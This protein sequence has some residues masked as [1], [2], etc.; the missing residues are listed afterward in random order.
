MLC[1]AEGRVEW[2]NYVESSRAATVCHQFLWQ[3]VIGQVYRHRPFYLMARRNE[4]VRGILPLFLVKSRL[5]GKSLTSMPFLDY[6]GICADDEMIAQNLLQCALAMMQE[7]GAEYVELRQCEAPA[8]SERARLDKVTM[9]LDLSAGVEGVWH[10]LPAK[11]R[12]QVRKAEKSGLHAC[13]GGPELLED[14]YL[15]FS[16]NMRDLGSPVHHRDFFAHLFAQCGI[17][18]RLILVREGQRAVG[19]LV[20]LFFRDTVIV[21]WASSLRQYL[22]KCPN[23]LLYWTAIQ[24]ACARGCR[25]FDFGRSSIG[26][27]TYNFKLQWGAEA[28]QIYWRVLGS[29]GRR[30]M[31]PS[32]SESK[33]HMM[34]TIWRY[35]PVPF[36]TVLGPTIRKYLTN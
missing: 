26:S 28:V 27:G 17:Q 31:A 11:V 35:L 19:G 12:N 18:A 14:F 13:V 20:C 1:G 34:R 24:Y 22:S 29:N 15:V 10:S 3:L 9:I 32:T 5:F 16:V 33:Y 7:H 2:D 4:R 6:G 36:T 8:Q 30:G 21:P 25:R 23:N